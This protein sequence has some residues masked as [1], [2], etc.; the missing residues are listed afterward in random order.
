MK[1]WWKY[2][3]NIVKISWKYRGNI[4]KISWT[5]LIFVIFYTDKI[6]RKFSQNLI[7]ML[8]SHYFHDVFK[9][10]SRYFHDIFTIFSRCFYDIFTILSWYYHNIFTIFP[11]YFH[12]I[13]MM[14]GDDLGDKGRHRNEKLFNSV[15][16]RITPK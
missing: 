2:R 12:D 11:L 13:F 5:Y 4:V 9:I 15:I 10:F 1:I 6:V 8:Y 3:V 14:M 16:A 7:S